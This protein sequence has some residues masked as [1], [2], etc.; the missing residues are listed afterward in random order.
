MR[1]LSKKMLID[2]SVKT[3]IV[4]NIQIGADCNLEEISHFTSLFKEFYNVFA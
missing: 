2:I 3:G 1:N 4:E